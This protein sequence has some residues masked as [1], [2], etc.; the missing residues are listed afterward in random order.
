M[1]LISEFGCFFK[2]SSFKNLKKNAFYDFYKLLFV[3]A[4]QMSSNIQE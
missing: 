1:L 2:V 3:K 4:T